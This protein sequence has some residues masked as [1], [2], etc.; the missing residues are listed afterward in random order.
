MVEAQ[1]YSPGVGLGLYPKVNVL[2]VMCEIFNTVD[3]G[4]PLIEGNDERTKRLYIFLF[5]THHSMVFTF[6][7]FITS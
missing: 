4:L 2:N 3:L 6:H 5:S 7:T 1:F